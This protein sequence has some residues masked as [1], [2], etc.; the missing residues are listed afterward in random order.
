MKMLFCILTLLS[1]YCHS[2]ESSDKT[3]LYWLVNNVE[4]LELLRSDTN[5][6]ESTVVDTTRLLMAA[7]P[8]YQSNLELAQRTSI[9]RLLKKIPNSCT[10]NRVKT[11]E[12]LNSSIYSLP[13]N[14]ALGLRLYSQQ[15]AIANFMPLDALNNTNELISLPSLFTGKEIYTLGINNGRSLGVFL[16]QQIKTLDEHNLVIRNGHEST[17]SLVKMLIKGRI[18][19]LIEYPLSVNEALATLNTSTKLD[20]LEIANSPDYIVGYVACSKGEIG[21]KIIKEI[22]VAL[23][24]LYQSS[25]FYHAHI[26]YLDMR[27]I[28]DFN[29]AYQAIFQV[30]IPM[31]EPYAAQ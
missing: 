17:L 8:Q 19:Y 28:P 23:Q 29:Q 26:R 31:K 11:T 4:R 1:F 14:I 2:F 5:T 21:E 24:Q 15:G 3:E 25:D 30:E 18:N 27:D 12:R 16:D 22:N 6:P 10:A 7:L 20:S 9:S 13:L